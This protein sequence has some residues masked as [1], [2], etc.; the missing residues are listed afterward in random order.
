MVQTKRNLKKLALNLP[1]KSIKHQ[2][3]TVHNYQSGPA[4]ILPNLYL[5]A[6][7]NATNTTQLD[8]F[9][10]NCVINVASEISLILP[11][12]I[13]YHHLKW[14]HCQRNLAQSEFA[15]AIHLIHQAHQQQ[16][17]VLVH[18]QQGIERSAA[19]IIAFLI[20]ASKTKEATWTLDHTVA[21]VKSKAP[22]IHPNM[23]LLYQL[24][25]YEKSLW[26]QTKRTRRM[27]R[28]GSVSDCTDSLT[29]QNK[30]QRSISCRGHVKESDVIGK[31]LDLYYHVDTNKH[32]NHD[33][34]KR[35]LAV[36]STLVVLAA[37]YQKQ[38]S[39][40]SIVMNFWLDKTFNVSINNH[41]SLVS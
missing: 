39:K 40:E 23:E 29:I 36:T 13:T 17:T 15:H 1:K 5:G 34:K 2:P 8:C 18:C 21:F 25:E 3:E 10:I 30:R 24:R 6:Y 14:T 37:I 22:G 4:H 32:C 33:T 16:K 9:R 38:Q 41:V 7:H 11:P 27:R 31:P 12:H 28:S 19:L 26:T 20:H 35:A